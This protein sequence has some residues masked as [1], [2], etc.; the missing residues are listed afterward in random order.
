MDRQIKAEKAWMI[1]WL[2]SE[3]LGGFEFQ[4]L[5]ALTMKEVKSL[6]T[7]PEPLHRFPKEMS[8][9]F[10]LE[11]QH[12]ED[13]Y[14]GRAD[15]IWLNRPSS[16]KVVY[17][18]LQLR[19]AG[20]KIATMAANILA[21]DFKVPFADYYSIDISVDVQIRRVFT[22]LGLTKPGE[23]NESINY[24]ARSLHP[25]FPGLLD[26]PCWEIGRNWCKPYNPACDKCYMNQ[27]CPSANQTKDAPSLT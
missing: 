25:E 22:R 11:I 19:G 7:Y 27:V 26:S 23:S 6:M 14:N 21:R 5:L 4:R 3:K 8:L 1:P 17:R 24:Q 10:H 15:N 12:I 18:F 9:N 13:Q 20:P 2:I 16:A